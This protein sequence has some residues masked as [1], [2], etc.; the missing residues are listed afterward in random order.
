MTP[1]N[2]TQPIVEAAAIVQMS[3]QH[4]KALLGA[5]SKN[6]AKWEKNF[7]E[8]KIPAEKDDSDKGKASAR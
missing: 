4:A 6:V 7:G 8:I 3:P 2:E 5:L 1:D